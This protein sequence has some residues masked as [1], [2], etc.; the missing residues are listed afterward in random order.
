[1]IG[2]NT[3]IAYASLGSLYSPGPKHLQV[4]SEDDDAPKSSAQ[5]AERVNAEPFFISMDKVRR[6][7]LELIF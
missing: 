4:L 1:M 2:A 7:L 6:E 3:E 5:I